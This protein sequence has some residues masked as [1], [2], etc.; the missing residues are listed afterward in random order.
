MNEYHDQYPQYHFN[1]NKGYPTKYHINMIMK[2]GILD[3]HRKSFKPIKNL[4]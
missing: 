4:L 3:I 1:Q 2:Y